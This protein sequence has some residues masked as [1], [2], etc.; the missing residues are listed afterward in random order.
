MLVV[1]LLPAVVVVGFPGAVEVDVSGAGAA[2]LAVV[3]GVSAR[4]VVVVGTTSPACSVRR[5][6]WD[7][8]VTVIP[9]QASVTTAVIAHQRRWAA[10]GREAAYRAVGI[11]QRKNQMRLW[12]QVGKRR[13]RAQAGVWAITYVSQATPS[14]SRSSASR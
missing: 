14:P 3:P 11:G 9:T 2:V 10:G 13:N 4:V 5:E 8:E 7:E 1:S 12:P 6:S